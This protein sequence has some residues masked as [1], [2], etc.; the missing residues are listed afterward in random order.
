MY[1]ESAGT[2]VRVSP[3]A[4][5]SVGSRRCERAKTSLLVADLGRDDADARPVERREH[6]LDRTG[7]Q[8][9][10]GVQHEDGGRRRSLADTA[11]IPPA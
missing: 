9:D 5:S 10:V 7:Q 4:R 11:L 8:P 3:S 2:P 1:S 6:G